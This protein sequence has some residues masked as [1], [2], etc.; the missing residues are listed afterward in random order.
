M[1]VY[2]KHG[3]KNLFLHNAMSYEEFFS[4]QEVIASHAEEIIIDMK[5][6]IEEIL[7]SNIVIDLYDDENIKTAK[8]YYE[9]ASEMIVITNSYIKNKFLGNK[10]PKYGYSYL[11]LGELAIMLQVHHWLMGFQD[12]L[13]N[14][15][16][17]YIPLFDKNTE[18]FFTEDSIYIYKY[19]ISRYAKKG[20]LNQAKKLYDTLIGLSQDNEVIPKELKEKQEFIDLWEN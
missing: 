20:L 7:Q 5:R 13:F 2:M 12:E 14:V 17:E 19:E 11:F 6:K 4:N 3:V 9:E 10:S 1:F 15:M 18:M 16:V 8:K